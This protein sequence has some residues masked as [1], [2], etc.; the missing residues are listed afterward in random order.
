M[1][2]ITTELEEQISSDME[3]VKVSPK[4]GIKAIHALKKTIKEMKEKYE[5]INEKLLEEIEKRYNQLSETRMN[6]EIEKKDEEL[7]E[8]LFRL[9][10]VDDRE[11]FE[12]IQFDRITYNINGYYKRDLEETNSEIIDAIKELEDIGVDV[13][14]NDFKISEYAYDYMEV[15]IDEYKKENTNFDRIKDTFDKIYWKCS[16]LISH[17]YVCFR[18]IFDNHIEEIEGEYKDRAEKILVSLRTNINKLEEERKKIIKSKRAL[19]VR[20]DKLIL[21]G[22][23]AGT[24]NINDF[25]KD[26]YES[27]YDELISKDFSKLSAEEKSNLDE[28]IKKLY[29]N[30]IEYSKFLEYRFLCDDMLKMREE[31]IKK[32]EENKA[33]KVKTT[34]FEAIK[35]E[36]IKQM[37]EIKKINTMIS[38]P[39]KQGLFGK[40]SKS[41]NSAELLRRN[42]LI[43]EVK[44][45]YLQ[46]DDIRVKNAVVDNIKE[47]STLLDVLKLASYYYGFMAK[48]IINKNNE[49]TDTEI[50]DM[51]R[52]IRDYINLTD[53]AVINN[54]NALEN[55]DLAIII[56]D[57]Y[58]LYGM[59]LTKENFM[60]DNVEDLLR[61]IKSIYDYNNIEK[62][63]WQLEEIDYILKAKELLKK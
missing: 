19:E 16:D 54:I 18:Q 37:E 39:K 52:N 11:A 25:K 12:K 49:V 48:S 55:R 4:N 6:P 42:N 2:E 53:F 1:S 61:R 62:S 44:K 59:N 17:I 45:L 22:F 3:F 46:L 15:L 57:R 30:L 14:T 24:L 43:Q 13:S 50:A 40:S 56:K 41:S 27:N 32:R 60:P 5:E 20:D 36:I 34:E 51:I 31:E 8:L 9:S 58:K 63:D 29:E 7:K 38:K 28:N 33:N 23:F 10:I 21:E 35:K 47:T 26:F